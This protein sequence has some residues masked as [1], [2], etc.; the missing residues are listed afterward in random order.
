MIN[1]SSFVQ[2]VELF[3]KIL[4][5]NPLKQKGIEKID[6]GTYGKD[7]VSETIARLLTEIKD[8]KLTRRVGN[9]VEDVNTVTGT[10][11]QKF[12]YR[13]LREDFIKRIDKSSI[14]ANHPEVRSYLKTFVITKLKEKILR[15]SKRT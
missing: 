1:C 14:F 7:K 6:E 5:S 9:L 12:I 10:L 11:P 2:G 13:V 4:M 3:W 15:H 8:P